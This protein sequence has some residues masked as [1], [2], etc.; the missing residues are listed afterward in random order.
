[1]GP[2]AAVTWTEIRSPELK[3]TELDESVQ[4]VAGL[5]IVQVTDVLAPALRTKKVHDL[6][7][8]GV[9]L[10]AA[11]KLE[12]VPLVGMGACPMLSVAEEE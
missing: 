12:S 8:W 7:A 2:P 10:T 4:L 3:L 6:P 9:V 1:M 5:L 11:V